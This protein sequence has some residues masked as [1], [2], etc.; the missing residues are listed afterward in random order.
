M[1]RRPIALIGSG[2]AAA[3]AAAAA[4]V[5]VLLLATGGEAGAP[6]WEYTFRVLGFTCY[7]A[8]LSALLALAAA[9]PMTRALARRDFPGRNLLVRL[10]ALPMVMPAIVGIF[11]IVAVYGGRGYLA[12]AADAAGL[13]WRPQL[14]GLGGILVAHVFFNLPLAIRLLLPAYAA[15]PS[16]SWR[17]S[18][19]LG[20]TDRDIL[21]I[22]EGPLL[23]QQLP[24]IAL[25]VFMLCFTTFAIALTLGGGPRATTLEVA[26]YQALRFDFDLRLGAILA[27]LQAGCCA[28]GAWIAWCLGRDMA[29]GQTT[30]VSIRRFDGRGIGA[31][32]FDATS[33]LL[34]ALFLVLPLIALV[35]RGLLGLLAT[36]P[37]ASLAGAALVSLA[38]GLGGGLL[39]TAMGYCIAEA[40]QQ[41]LA[42][43]RRRRA[44]L[45]GLVGRLGLFVSPM[46]I[47][48]GIF[49]AATGHIDLYRFAA[50][51]VVTLSAVLALPF[52]LSV[53]EPALAQSAE[54]HD[55][56][57]AALGIAGWHRFI[58]IDWPH[59][60]RP[61]A[62]ALA[63][64]SVI[65]M[66]DLGAIALFG[67]QDL[68][69]L[70]LLLYNQLGA[71]RLDG[72]AGTAL[73]LM[74]LA[75]GLY[76]CI[77]RVVGGRGLH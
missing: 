72:A 77:E 28:L 76:W 66:G 40:R 75:L 23:R 30:Q 36:A 49:L 33:I 11:G 27:L 8:L 41:A 22:I 15:I 52:V 50:I 13:H 62:T 53:L 65:A 45:L 44:L 14:Y 68:T 12:L 24:G 38:L 48:T 16:E 21:R 69:N 70:T 67:H 17:L 35:Q 5:I 34:G 74:S 55:R 60:R 42:G 9:V 37:V 26:I 20:M 2:L 31:R 47:G 3:L 25:V 57:C 29:L 46:V 18:A 7:Q 64:A 32:A 59:L 71:Y 51:G 63:L 6:R 56:L 39:A 19:Q 73:V 4:M 58:E 61:I 1:G 54:R 43:G 10:C